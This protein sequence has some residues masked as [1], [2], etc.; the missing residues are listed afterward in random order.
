MARRHEFREGDW[1]SIAL[2]LDEIISAHSGED[3]FEEALKLLV[4]RLAFEV[5][6][7]A[8][9]SFIIKHNED[10]AVR[11]T[12]R[13]IGLAGERWRGILDP[14]TVTC[15]SGPELVRCAAILNS[16]S[17]LT[18]DLVGLDAIFETIVNKASKGQ[19]GQYFTPRHVIAEVVEMIRPSPYERLVDPACGS[20][21]FLRHALLYE[22]KCSVW[23][24]D[25]DPRASRVARVMLAASGQPASR[26]MRGDSLRRPDRKLFP[27]TVPVIEE[28]MRAQDAKFRG[29]DVVLTNPPFAGDVG[30]EYSDS[31]E[32]ARGRRVERD[33]LFVERCLELLK[34]GGRMAIVLPY[35][36][37]G[38]EQ[39][40]YMRKW[41]FEHMQVVA[42]LSLGR[43]TFQP[44]TSQKACVL[45]GIKRSRRAVQFRNDEVLFFISERDGKD[46]RGRLIFRTDG[47]TV[48]HDLSEATPLVRAR[49]DV[50]QAGA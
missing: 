45:I 50:L 14:G 12:N 19:K 36:K 40:G 2:R 41:L 46:H 9:G 29:F 17:L 23:G 10:E 28:L 4:A 1:E 44:H 34:P 8:P 30:E 7:G 39:W 16:V 32:L 6:G 3:P 22:P 13:L 27:E 31:Y 26:V 5:S 38:G 43:N 18:D 21:G 35:N 11:E 15:L 25:Q 48:E 37:V 47:R 24:F 33:V 42:V 49:F 20:G